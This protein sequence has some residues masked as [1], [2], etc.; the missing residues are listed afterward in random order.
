MTKVPNYLK[1]LIKKYPKITGGRKN[2]KNHHLR[3]QKTL[4]LIKQYYSRINN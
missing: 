2:F 3:I 4:K 1:Y